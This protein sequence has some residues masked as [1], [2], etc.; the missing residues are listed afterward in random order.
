ML[1]DEHKHPKTPTQSYNNA[2]VLELLPSID[3]G[4]SVAEQDNLLES[5]RVET[6]AF[7]DLYYDKVDL[8][9]GTKGS[10]KSALYRIFVEFLPDLLLSQ[11]RAVVAH[12]VNRPGDPVFLAFNKEF[13]QLSEEAFIDFWCIYIISLVHE[14]FIKNARYQDL[15]SPCIS[16]IEVFRKACYDARIPEIKAKM[17]LMD[18]LAWALTALKNVRPELKYKPPGQIGE[19][20][21]SLFPQKDATIVAHK[22]DDSV[23]LPRYV[24]G[25]RKSLEA[26][27][28]TAEISIWFMIDKLDEI[29]PRRSELERRA[30]RGLLRTIRL[31]SSDR[32]RVKV[33]LRDDMLHEIVEGG[34]GFTAL[35]H[36]TA[37][38]ADTLKWNE[39][40]ILSV[41]VNRIFASHS[42]RQFC[43][44]D[45]D[46]LGASLDYRREAFYKVFPAS[47]HTGERQ[48]NTL[49]WI[50]NHTSDGNGVVTPRDVIDLLKIAMQYQ[51][52]VVHSDPSGRSTSI[53]GSQAIQYGLEELSKNKRSNYL[54]AEFPHLWV[55]I[56][57]FEGGKTEYSEKAVRKLL[58]DRWKEIVLDLCSIGLLSSGTAQGDAVYKIPA[59]YRKGL[60]LSQGRTN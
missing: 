59:L 30:L 1:H 29:F 15:L 14:Q 6:S 9:P 44:V 10:G 26:I 20:S 2:Q 39:D 27:L 49:R 36:L 38:K 3:L 35:T 47:V 28:Q 25:L 17:A 37:R 22:P 33:F 21:L 60:K 13:E 45:K 53:V 23:R 32:V 56:Q 11:R 54:Q 24:D 55:H 57:K 18:I 52:N 8:I 16:Q 12:G 43:S 4:V 40:Q 5:A 41:I 31:F 46:H 19:Y 50:F 58:G 48:S 7:S 42:L 51:Q 34:Q